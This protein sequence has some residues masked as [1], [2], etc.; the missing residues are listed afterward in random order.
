MTNL[1]DEV[2][3]LGDLP[4][5]KDTWYSVE[6]FAEHY[7]PEYKATLKFPL[8]EDVY[9]TGENFEWV[10]GRQERFHLVDDSSSGPRNHWYGDDL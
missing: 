10:Y 4:L 5:L 3:V 9:W 8:E 7:V 1:Q 6:L 2:P